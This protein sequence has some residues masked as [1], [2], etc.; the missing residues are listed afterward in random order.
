VR[1]RI[2][3]KAIVG[4]LFMSALA[5][6]AWRVARKETPLEYHR[7][8]FLAALH[9]RWQDQFRATGPE[10][11]HQTRAD[12]MRFHQLALVRLG[13]LQERIFV[14]SNRPA[15]KVHLA[16]GQLPQEH[17]S[18]STVQSRGT[19]RLVVIAVREDMP[20]WEKLVRLG[21]VR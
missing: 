2:I 20:E 1:T 13:Y 6:G 15:D 11:S 4:V 17:L 21:D 9:G 7:K 14:I 19:N 12:R 18:F 10:V 8:E 16:V 3:V 5:A